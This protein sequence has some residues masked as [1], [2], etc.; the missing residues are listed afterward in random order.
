MTKYKKK[1]IYS[2][3]FLLIILIVYSGIKVTIHFVLPRELVLSHINSAFFKTLGKAIKYDSI[4]IDLFGNIILKNFSLAN[5]IDFNDD[6]TLIKSEELCI[7]TKFLSLFK[8][9]LMIKGFVMKNPLINLVK[10]YGISYTK[11]LH[12]V[13]GVKKIFSSGEEGKQA[14]NSDNTFFDDAVTID[15]DDADIIYDEFFKNRKTHIKF[16]NVDCTFSMNRKSA[17]IDLNG[18]VINDYNGNL[19]KG[20][21][22]VYG[23]FSG[24]KLSKISF[25]MNE[26]NMEHLN[27]FLSEKNFL[28]KYLQGKLSANGEARLSGKDYAV[29]GKFTGTKIFLKENPDSGSNIITND[30]INLKVK[31]KISSDLSAISL[32]DIDLSDGIADFNISLEKKNRNEL[33]LSFKSNKINLRE[34][35][36]RIQPVENSSYGGQLSLSGKIG[37]DMEKDEPVNI[38]LNVNTM[39]FFISL[40]RK[41]YLHKVS[42]CNTSIKLNDKTL[43]GSVSFKYNNSD[44]RMQI[45]SEISTIS[46]LKSKSEIQ[47][48]SENIDIREVQDFIIY[49]LD[50]LYTKAYDDMNRGYNEIFFLKEPEGIFLNNNDFMIAF[51]VKNIIY[52]ERSQLQNLQLAMRLQKGVLRTEQFSVA[53]LDGRYSFLVSGNFNQEYP[54]IRIEG[55]FLNMNLSKLN[56]A[57]ERKA[58]GELNISFSYNTN[59]YRIGHFLENGKGDFSV[60][61]RNGKISGTKIQERIADFLNRNEYNG[62][63]VKNLNV[64][65]LNFVF[66][67]AGHNCYVK[68]FALTSDE[69][70]FNTSGKYKIDGGLTM[71]LPLSIYE[72]EPRKGYS[73]PLRVTGN[74]LSPCLG[75]SSGKR[76]DMVCFKSI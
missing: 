33:Y 67:Q 74:L 46:P 50:D 12:D 53:G 4:K 9:K 52:D 29:S 59:A 64:K 42:D 20:F 31:G 63:L 24:G 71:S 75:F 69:A 6:V 10:K 56:M 57:K 37:Y 17:H 18:F 30:E 73:I 72:K 36:K 43:D 28:S 58:E 76:K 11:M 35:N 22:G 70:V 60:S 44:Y 68:N 3:S 66:R 23:S 14:G 7:K 27:I 34:L 2:I 1:I 49:S 13:F 8:G 15:I 48:H 26:L 38:E 16:S 55:E 25:K 61:L 62:D 41:S 40:N 19:T 45:K 51:D 47:I 54:F 32:S 21:L 39:D 5:G 65:S